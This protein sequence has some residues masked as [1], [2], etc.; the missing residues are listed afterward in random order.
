MVGH[1]CMETMESNLRI[2]SLVGMGQEEPHSQIFCYKRH[3]KL[4]GELS[5]FNVSMGVMGWCEQMTPDTSSVQFTHRDP[6]WHLLS[7]KLPDSLVGGVNGL[8]C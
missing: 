1:W 5:L 6:E 8:S 2:L 3:C 4:L 7:W